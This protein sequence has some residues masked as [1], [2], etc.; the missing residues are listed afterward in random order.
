MGLVENLWGQAPQN[1]CYN[2]RRKE[3]WHGDK[4]Q[5]L[6]FDKLRTRVCVRL[7]PS[8]RASRRR[9]ALRMVRLVELRTRMRVWSRPIA[10]TRPGR[11]QVHLVRFDVQRLG[12]PLL[13]DAPP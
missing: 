9:E 10:S 3:N 1:L 8:S 12:L 2:I 5:T 4:M 13:P 7:G 6:R 11:Q